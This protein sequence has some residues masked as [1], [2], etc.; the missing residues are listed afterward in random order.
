MK[1]LVTGASGYI[2]S[3]FVKR[4]MC[5]GHHVVCASRRDPRLTGAWVPFDLYSQNK[6]SLQGDI[7]LV[8]HMAAV[9]RLAEIDETAEIASANMLVDAAGIVDARIIFISSQTARAD[10]PTLYGRIK[11]QIEQLVLSN[12]GLVVRLGQVY[13][14]AENGLFGMLVD[15]VRKSPVLPAFI[16]SPMLQPVHIDDAVASI[17]Q[18]ASSDDY[19]SRVYRIAQ[20]DSVSF[21]V[22]LKTIARERLH[23]FRLFVPVP[24]VVVQFI[25]AVSGQRLATRLGLR[26]LDSLFNIPI[27]DT[28]RDVASLGLTLR[29]LN[30]GMQVSADSR[31]RMLIREGHVLLIYISRKQPGLGPVKRYVR[32]I[33]T[34]REGVPLRLPDAA[35]RWPALL[36]LCE[37]R[38]TADDSLQQEFEWRLHS[39]TLVCEASRQGAQRFLGYGESDLKLMVVFRLVR[40]IASEA[41]VRIVRLLVPAALI[42][43]RS[44]R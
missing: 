40:A 4:A 29:G 3:S 36:A 10:A 17:I 21:T 37:G 42:R 5:L 18:L 16:P 41:V 28:A 1:I 20:S 35:V 6:L 32:M 15:L 2:G 38:K 43:I 26:R 34:L 8:V 24:V 30:T 44:G 39:A 23:R 9:S 13:G 19:D 27:M 31:R 22:F 14:G 33:E 25:S 12:G 11:W 7:D